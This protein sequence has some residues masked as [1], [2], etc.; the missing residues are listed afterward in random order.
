MGEKYI[1]GIGLVLLAF[2][3]LGLIE[4]TFTGQVV[5]D[6]EKVAITFP[7]NGD[8]P[9]DVQGFVSFGF[10][11]PNAVFKVD[12]RE[13]DL[14]IF[15][16]SETIPGLKLGYEVQDKKIFGGLPVMY[17]D[18]I[19]IIDGQPHTLVYTFSKPA[20]KQSIHLD[21][22]LLVESSFSGEK[23]ADPITGM[24]VFEQWLTIQSNMGMDVK[25]G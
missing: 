10:S 18:A 16:T 17:S 9:N 25:F 7:M 22:K 19:D 6:R 4:G 12:D 23:S 2:L 5:R 13:A 24:A 21:G 15:M 20:N 3:V 8:F 1:M 11:F 14:L